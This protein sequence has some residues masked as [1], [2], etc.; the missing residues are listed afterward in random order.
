MEF[1][2]TNGERRADLCDV[3]YLPD[4]PR[5]SSPRVRSHGESQL[6]MIS[7]EGR[8]WGEERGGRVSTADK[9]VRPESYVPSCRRKAD[10]TDEAGSGGLKTRDGCQR[11]I[12]SIAVQRFEKSGAE[13]YLSKKTYLES[14]SVNTG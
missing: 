14:V 5:C 3:S 7:R 1:S 2:V 12:R 10:N 8:G 9:A 11:N 6:I 13:T 4:D